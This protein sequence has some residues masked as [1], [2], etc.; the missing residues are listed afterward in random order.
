MAKETLKVYLSGKIAGLPVE[1]YQQN[2]AQAALKACEWLTLHSADAL[3][4]GYNLITGKFTIDKKFIEDFRKA[5][6]EGAYYFP[7]GYKAHERGYAIENGEVSEGVT[8]YAVPIYDKSGT[9]FGTICCTGASDNMESIRTLLVDDLLKCSEEL[10][11]K[12]FS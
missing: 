10:T 4:H 3:A 11:Q 1:E 7:K 6:E 9:L 8:A 12:L 2:F 5:I